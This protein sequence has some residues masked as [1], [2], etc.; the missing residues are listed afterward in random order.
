MNDAAY[1]YTSNVMH[2]RYFPVKYQFTYRVFSLFIDIDRLDDVA[3]QHTWF[4]HNRFNV[5]SLYDQN[6]GARTQQSWRSWINQVLDDHH[7][8]AAKHRVYLL[9][10]PRILGYTFN[11]LSLWFCYDE[12]NQLQ[13]VIG[14]VSNTFKQH[15]H[16]VMHNNNQPL[17]LPLTASHQKIFPVSPFIN[18]QQEY[19]FNIHAPDETL[20]IHINQH[21]AGK[22]MLLAAQYGNRHLFSN[23]K[24]WQCFFGIP[25]MTLKV[26]TMI[27]WQALK[28]WLKG[29]QYHSPKSQSQTESTGDTQ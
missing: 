18:M 5:F 6:H 10:F 25:L 4:S 8:P 17:D 16:Y 20:Q 2:A 15:H 21:E 26:I 28:I 1:I 14:E 22:P 29:G 27:H 19:H 9:C 23:K 11:P 12:N 13:A 24:L 7:L 3:K